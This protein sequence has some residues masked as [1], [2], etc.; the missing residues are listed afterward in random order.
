V[1][2]AFEFLA[3]VVGISANIEALAADDAKYDFRKSDRLN[4]MCENVYKPGF[5]FHNL[6]FASEL[7]EGNSIFLDGRNHGWRLIEVAVELL[8]YSLEL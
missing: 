8:E 3:D 6:T 5:A 4:L 1:G 7:V 2:A